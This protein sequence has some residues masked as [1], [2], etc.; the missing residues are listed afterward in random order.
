VQKN[1]GND[2]CCNATIFPLQYQ[3]KPYIQ[4]KAM[5]QMLSFLALVARA[6]SPMERE[7]LAYQAHVSQGHRT[8]AS[9]RG[10]DGQKRT[11]GKTAY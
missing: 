2:P 1:H 9:Q 11:V 4:G 5:K 7:R 8:E 6:V 10:W 3:G